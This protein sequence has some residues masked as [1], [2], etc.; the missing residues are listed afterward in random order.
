MG[1]EWYE[2]ASIR[3]QVDI[4]D[5]EKEA[6]KMKWVF[7]LSLNNRRKT[8]INADSAAAGYCYVLPG[9]RFISLDI[10]TECYM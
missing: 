9:D 1:Y 3:G 10:F 2:R 7:V 6:V 8:F 5:C 4:V